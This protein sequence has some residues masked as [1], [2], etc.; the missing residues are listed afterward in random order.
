MLKCKLISIVVVIL[1]CC[2]ITD[3]EARLYVVQD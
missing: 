3:A 2:G 1:L